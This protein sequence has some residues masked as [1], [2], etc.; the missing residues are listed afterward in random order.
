M[1]RLWN[2]LKVLLRRTR[3]EQD[4]QDEIAAHLDLDTQERIDSGTDPAE[5]HREAHRDFG[6][7]LRMAEDTR[8]TWGWTTAEQWLQDLRYGL[9]NLVNSPTFTIVS[10]LTLALGIG[11]TTSIFSVVNAALLRPLPYPNPD[12]L[13][14]VFSVNPAPGG[15]LWVVSPADFRDWREQSGSFEN[16][17][18]FSG[19]GISLWI[20]ERP[21]TIPSSRV[22]WNFFDTLEVRPLLGKGFERSDELKS[23]ESLVLSHRLWQTRFG[24]DPAV[25]GRQ[26]RTDRGSLTIVAVMPPQF[27]F[28]DNTEAWTTMG[29]CGEMTRRATRYWRTV[30]RLRDGTSLQA[31]ES[32]VQSI[33]SRLAEVY[34]KDDKNWTVQVL[35]FKR[36]LVRDVNQALWI[37]MGAVGFVIVIACANVAGLTLVRSASRRR[38]IG[39]RLALGANRWRVMRQLFIEGL[40]LSFFGTVIG[41]L[42][43]KWSIVAFFDLLPR[44]IFTPLIRFREVVQLD[45][46]V[47]MFAVGLS[48]FTAIILTLTPAWTSLKLALGESVRSGGNKTHMRGEHRIYKLLVVGQFACAIVL[49]AGAGLMIQSFIHMLNV[50]HGYQPDGMMI[51]SFPQPAANRPAFSEEALERIKAAPGVESVA[52][53]SANRF[54]ELNF[55]FNREDRP[56]P[57]GD[58]LV[59]YS[60]VSADYFHVLKSRLVGG[61]GFEERDASPA[62]SVAVINERLAR[63]YFPGEDPIGRKI[64]LAYNN[65]RVPHEI[66]GVMADVRQDAPGVPVW[67]EILVHWKQLPWLSGTLVIRAKGDP[68]RVQKSVQEAIWSVD[69]NLPASTAETMEQVLGAEVATPRLYAILFGLF[70]AVA[71]MLA[72]LGIYGLQAYIVSRRTNEMAIRVAVGAHRRNITRLVIGDGVRLSLMGI[73]AGLVGTIVLTR[74]MRSLLFDVSPTD[75]ATL[76]SVVLLLLCVAWAGCYIPARRAARTDP[77]AVLRHE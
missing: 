42:L 26:V 64:V 28:P 27:R 45:S 16:L 68:A 17:A 22:T 8:T 41:L 4:L 3:L 36:A 33:A 52:L 39:V 50:E 19:D 69:K 48:A 2:R 73:A 32:E 12:R 54:G 46:R 40:L 60:S 15:G 67:P 18:A 51:M 5:A 6:N 29:C 37:L 55:P 9:R 31:A 30:A 59:R 61:R 1:Q 66:I 20:S 25:I 10:L 11:A 63:A 74:L 38:E 56:F 34:P 70:S 7:V 77:M 13:V 43:A 53:M 14:S 76:F 57:N 24:G 65:Q 49:L 72:V 75:P 35:P 44:T 71:V 58:V 47:L 23:T 62:P 21:E